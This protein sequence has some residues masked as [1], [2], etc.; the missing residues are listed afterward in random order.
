MNGKELI[1]KA[2]CTVR[3]NVCLSN[4]FGLDLGNKIIDLGAKFVRLY[5]NE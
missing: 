4:V 1:M 3:I 5:S 2:Q